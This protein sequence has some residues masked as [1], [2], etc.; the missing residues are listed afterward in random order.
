MEES[1]V[2]RDKKKN[3]CY[4]AT[5]FHQLAGRVKSSEA[6]SKVQ[7]QQKKTLNYKNQGSFCLKEYEE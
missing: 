5:E 2:E 6:E 3:F 4:Y 1:G 7:F